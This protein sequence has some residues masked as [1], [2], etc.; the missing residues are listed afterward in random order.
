MDYDR[1][2]FCNNKVNNDYVLLS[3]NNHCF[4]KAHLNCFKSYENYLV[5]LIGYPNHIPL[6]QKLDLMWN[7][8]YKYIENRLVCHCRNGFFKPH[9]NNPES[10][11]YYG[12]NYSF[13][14]H[15]IKKN[16]K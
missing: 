1:C 5:S 8:D 11:F 4:T 10:K 13:A 6:N 3:C 9:V 14:Q 7:R 2:Y 15:Q 12:L 16:M